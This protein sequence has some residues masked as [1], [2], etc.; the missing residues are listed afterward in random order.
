LRTIG[1]TGPL[2]R[3]EL[4]IFFEEFLARVD[5]VQLAGEPQRSAT[6]LVRGLKHLPISYR[7][8]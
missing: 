8:R 1:R 5:D 4:R 3:L 7:V 2:A 6:V